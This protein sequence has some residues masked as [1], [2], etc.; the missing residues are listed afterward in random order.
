MPV[1]IGQRYRDRYDV[2][3]RIGEGAFAHVYRAHDAQGGRDVALKVLKDPYLTVKDVVERFQREVFA[4]ASISSPH[5]VA[6]YDFG[7][8][9]DDFYIATEF[10]E[11]PSL[12]EI[13]RAR[14][15]SASD[16]HV[17]VGQIAHAL[18]AAHK[19]DIVHRDLKPENVLLVERPGGVW[20]VKVL[21]F[22]F[23]KLPELERKLG[24]E[25]LTRKGTCFGTPQ[26]L[27]PEQIRG[28]S[29]DGGADLFALGVIAYEMLGGR[30]PWDGDDPREVMMAVLNR[31]PPPIAKLHA[32]MQPR[33]EEVNRFLLRALGKDR[34]E[35]PADAPEFFRELGTALFGTSVPEL[36]GATPVGPLDS[37]SSQSIE[38][39]VVARADQTEVNE[40]VDDDRKTR[41]FVTERPQRRGVPNDTIRSPAFDSTSQESE[42]I[43]V[44]RSEDIPIFVA[45]GGR[46]KTLPSG[47]LPSLDESPPR[48]PDSQ[49]ATLPLVAPRLP[50]LERRRSPWRSFVIFLVMVAVAAGAFWLGRNLK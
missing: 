19:Q 4:V 40:T 31:L 8:S 15:W 22:G 36:P 23:A 34:A 37:V 27:S 10:V 48:G 30:R 20:Q 33:L 50:P 7:I 38:L 21:D 39:H 9:D 18:D 46:P 5:V 17:I 35:R 47:Y 45:Q 1:R 24:L 26:Y 14:A 11:G 49:K 12:R 25:P 6:L 16:V 28:R 2:Q 13:M 41:Q 29:L 42:K 32:S 44:D 43:I 3:R